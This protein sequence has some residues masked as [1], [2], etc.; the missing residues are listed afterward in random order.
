MH[1]IPSHKLEE[2]YVAVKRR[3]DQGIHHGPPHTN[4]IVITA[5]IKPRFVAEGR[6]I[7]SNP[8][9]SESLPFFSHEI[10]DFI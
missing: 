10:Q 5:Q 3:Q 8:L 7:G 9:Q 6:R 1:P 2:R 4:M